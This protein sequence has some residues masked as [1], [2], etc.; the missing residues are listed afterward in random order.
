MEN[1][2][3]S[4]PPTRAISE[5]VKITNLKFGGLTLYDWYLMVVYSIQHFVTFTYLETPYFVCPGTYKLP[6]GGV[7]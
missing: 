4:K 2:K 6:I 5:W 1:K 3:C 7:Q